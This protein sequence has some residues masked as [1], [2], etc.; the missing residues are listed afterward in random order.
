MRHQRPRHAA[1]AETLGHKQVG[2]LG[3]RP[4]ARHIGHQPQTGEAHG[5]PIDL[6]QNRRLEALAGGEPRGGLLGAHRYAG[7]GDAKGG[8]QLGQSGGV[9]QG[10][11]YVS[12]SAS[13]STGDRRFTHRAALRFTFY[14]GSAL[15]HQRQHLLQHQAIGGH[16][17]AKR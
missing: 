17:L 14:V 3:I 11:R 5:L 10:W 12:A 2:Q 9:I 6:G 8:D 1:P 7:V 4:V 13:S 15:A 16:A